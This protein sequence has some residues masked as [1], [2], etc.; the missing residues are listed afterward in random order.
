MAQF[1]ARTQTRWNRTRHMRRGNRACSELSEPWSRRTRVASTSAG[2]AEFAH[3]RCHAQLMNGDGG[4]LRARSASHASGPNARASDS[5]VCVTPGVAG[6]ACVSRTSLVRTASPMTSGRLSNPAFSPPA[7]CTCRR[8]AMP[9]LLAPAPEAVRASAGLLSD[10]ERHRARRFAF[11]RD[12]SRFIVARARL[13]QLL[14]A[15]L[16]VR[17]QAVE[18]EYGAY[19]KPVLSRRFADS[20]LH[21]NVSHCDDVAAYAFSGGHAIGIDVEAVREI[22]DADNIAVRYFSRLENATYRSLKPCHRPL[23][24]L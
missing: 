19:G 11:D 21:F 15:R 18:F 9:T 14:G 16:G 10:A 13:R 4:V 2:G 22:S 24:F 7:R 17:A 6:G 5:D 8:R 20:D 3:A 1:S 12:A 23:G